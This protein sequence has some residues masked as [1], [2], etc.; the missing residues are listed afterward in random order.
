M[1][2]VEQ[3]ERA[4][5]LAGRRPRDE[6]DPDHDRPDG[7]RGA[8]RD[9]TSTP[10]AGACVALG[11]CHACAWDLD[12]PRPRSCS[13]PA[14]VG[15]S[16]PRTQGVPLDRRPAAPCG[17]GRRRRRVPRRRSSRRRDGVRRGLEDRARAASRS[18]RCRSTVVAGGDTRQASVRAA[19]GAVSRRRSTS[20]PSRRGAAVRAARSLRVGRR[21]GRRRGRRRDPGPPRHRHREAGPEDVVVS[22][23]SRARSSRWRRRRR[24]SGRPPSVRARRADAAGASRSTDD[25]SLL[26]AGGP[27]R[28]ARSPATRRTSRSPRCSTSRTAEARM[29][30]ALT[31][32]PPGSASGSTCTRARPGRAAVARRRAVRGR[33]RPRRSFRRRRRLPRARRR[34]A[35]R[36]RRWATSGSTSPTPT[37]PTAGIGGLELLG[38]TVA[39]R[40][41]RR[42][43]RRRHAMS[44]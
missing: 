11:V 8:P 20:S 2:V 5:R 9:A 10:G 16:A 44:P 25:A 32:S 1:V 34:A 12:P 31:E 28:C 42:I 29:G 22:A 27:R 4:D 43:S 33:R 18:R 7:L 15:G 41:G 30:G 23:R 19:L 36:G 3:A 40:P 21:G 38:R 37:R 35:G 26:E 39:L 6:R 17:R 14:R 13:P 24:R